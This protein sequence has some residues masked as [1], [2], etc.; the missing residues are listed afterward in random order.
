MLI[1]LN[2]EPFR[3]DG[4]EEVI[5]TNEMMVDVSGQEVPIRGERASPHV[6]PAD[7]CQCQ[8]FSMLDSNDGSGC[9]VDMFNGVRDG[10]V[11]IRWVEMAGNACMRGL[12]SSGTL[13]I[14]HVIVAL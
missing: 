12:Q 10:F 8:L 9:H 6:N 1:S 14:F 7:K 4:H 2:F 13:C 11:V 3:S 5:S